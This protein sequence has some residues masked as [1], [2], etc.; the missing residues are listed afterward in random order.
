MFE[1]AFRTELLY[2]LLGV[3]IL[4]LVNAALTM[5][6]AATAGEFKV[7][8]VARF[9][10]HHILPDGGALLILAAGA[11]A[12]SELSIVFFAAAAAATTKYLGKIVT[13]LQEK[14]WQNL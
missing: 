8:E 12:H 4:I 10:S 2:A 14:G 6:K 7:A 1:L 13:R 9:V 3:F 5:L 11:T